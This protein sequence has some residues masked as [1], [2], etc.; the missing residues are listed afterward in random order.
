MLMAVFRSEWGETA[1]LWLTRAI[2][3][4]NFLA[5]KGGLCRKNAKFSPSLC[6]VEASIIFLLV[7][8]FGYKGVDTFFR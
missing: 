5:F 4:L 3:E 8:I 1:S 6:V 7:E 2:I